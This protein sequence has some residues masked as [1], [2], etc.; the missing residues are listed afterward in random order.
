MFTN[1]ASQATVT[2]FSGHI[3]V[4][5]FAEADSPLLGLRFASSMIYL[6]SQLKKMLQRDQNH[7]LQKPNDAVKSF[8]HQLQ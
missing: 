5:I 8:Q 2:M 3:I 6:E 4:A 7:C 1:D